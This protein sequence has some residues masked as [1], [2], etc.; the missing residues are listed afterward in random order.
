M[1]KEEPKNWDMLG[2]MYLLDFLEFLKIHGLLK[3]DV[4]HV[5][6]VETYIKYKCMI[7]IEDMAKKKGK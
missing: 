1:K 5:A 2:S 4:D 6:I 7:I 3:D